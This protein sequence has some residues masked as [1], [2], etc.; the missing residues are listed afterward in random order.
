MD[1]NEF[2]FLFD[3]KIK[4]NIKSSFD[5]I[6]FENELKNKIKKEALRK[7]SLEEKINDF[8]NYEIEISIGKIGVIA[9]LLVIIPT[10]FTIYE[11]K[12]IIN[13]N[14]KFQSENINYSNTK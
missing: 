3:E 14:I 9:A 10:T 8:L 11:G 2:E 12:R 4:T 5:D 7:K 1:N 13:N 6:T